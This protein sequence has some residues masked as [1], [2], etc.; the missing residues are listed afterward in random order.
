MIFV[1]VFFPYETAQEND[2]KL[3][4]VAQVLFFAF[5]TRPNPSI[6]LLQSAGQSSSERHNNKRPNYF[7]SASKAVRWPLLPL[8]AALMPSL[9]LWQFQL[10][11]PEKVKRQKRSRL[12]NLSNGSILALSVSLSLFLCLV[13]FR[14]QWVGLVRTWKFV[15]AFGFG[16]EIIS[17]YIGVPFCVFLWLSSSR[18]HPSQKYAESW[19]LSRRSIRVAGAVQSKWIDRLNRYKYQWESVAH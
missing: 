2:T 17:L 15:G 5:E 6:R 12:M 11:G 14:F 10:L 8:C 13:A 4:L 7:S 3:E 19:D 9:A 1:Y 18:L 16:T